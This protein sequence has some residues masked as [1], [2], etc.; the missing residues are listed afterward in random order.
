MCKLKMAK[1]K[2]NSIISFLLNIRKNLD[3][4]NRAIRFIQLIKDHVQKY[5]L[6]I[7]KISKFPER[8]DFF[9][10]NSSLHGV[11]FLNGRH[12]VIHR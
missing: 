8:L 10:K 1:G 11:Q 12:G 9:L 7:K 3:F 4:K 5:Y 6:N 2:L